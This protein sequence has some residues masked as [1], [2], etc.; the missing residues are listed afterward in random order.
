MKAYFETNSS[1]Y[2]KIHFFNSHNNTCPPHFH[3][4]IELYIVTDGKQNVTINSQ[5]RVLKKGEMSIA[6]PYDIHSY[7]T[8][9]ESTNTCLIIPDDMAVRFRM[10]V[11]KK[12]NVTPFITDQD[13]VK[14]IMNYIRQIETCQEEDL[15]IRGYV[16]IILGTIYDHLQFADSKLNAS[17]ELYSMVLYYLEDNFKEN[18]TL[19][20]AA[21]DLGYSPYYLSRFFN[22]Y[23]Q[24]SFNDYI[25]MIRLRNFINI[26]KENNFNITYC[27]YES[28]FT[29]IR[30][31]NRA[32]KKEFEITPK[33][34]IAKTY[35]KGQ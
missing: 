20:K 21:S 30:T 2:T 15:L 33:E 19:D 22:R 14:T 29:S 5:S 35:K 9:G 24:C 6:L 7:Q 28:G 25:N 4:Q 23:F 32:F 26:L 12:Q 31:F 17:T 34:Y 11:D 10:M 18:L 8:I 13:T 1:R 3:S 27:A 16:Y